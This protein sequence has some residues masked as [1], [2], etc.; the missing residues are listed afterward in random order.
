MTGAPRAA[1]SRG[2]SPRYPVCRAADRATS[3]APPLWT[4]WGPGSANPVHGFGSGSAN[5]VGGLGTAT[6]TDRR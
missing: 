1:D 6:L 2:R 3:P 5:P 4:A